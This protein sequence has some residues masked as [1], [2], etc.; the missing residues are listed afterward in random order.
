MTLAAVVWAAWP[1]VRHFVDRRRVAALTKTRLGMTTTEVA[2]VMGREPDCVVS[3]GRSSVAYF[4]GHAG[5]L[6]GHP[7]CGSLGPHEVATWDDLPVVYAAAEIAFD[8]SGRAVALGFCG[9]GEAK[10]LRGRPQ[11]CMKFLAPDARPD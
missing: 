7:P 11:D 5:D 1:L 4:A 3:V 2:R 9:E 6:L 10:S 8:A